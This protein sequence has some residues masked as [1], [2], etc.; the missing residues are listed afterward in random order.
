M[1]YDSSS[2]PFTTKMRRI[3]DNEPPFDVKDNHGPESY[4]PPFIEEW[5]EASEAGEILGNLSLCLVQSALKQ[6]LELFIQETGLKPPAGRGSWFDRYQQFFLNEYEIDWT[7]GPVPVKVLEDLSLARNDIQHGG[8]LT[9]KTT[10]QSP[11]YARR[12]PDSLFTEAFVVGPRIAVNRE[13]L[14]AAIQAVEEFCAY[15]EHQR[16]GE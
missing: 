2:E 12:F 7:K 8:T 16:L 14:T 5:I 9:T 3:N 15:L 6:F 13:S 11:E 1:L 4:D 10:I